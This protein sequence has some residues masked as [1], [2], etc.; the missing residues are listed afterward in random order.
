MDRYH[1]TRSPSPPSKRRRSSPSFQ[2]DDSDFSN[3]RVGKYDE[4]EKERLDE[5]RKIRMAK[6][7]A[8]NEE[9]EKKMTA[10]LDEGSK[11][12][13]H[14]YDIDDFEKYHNVLD[15]GIKTAKNSILEVNEIDI[16]G[17]DEEEQMQ[18][19]LG[20]GSFSSSK[21]KVV[22]DNHDSAAT[23]AAAKN[24]ERKYRQYM[25]RKG[26]FNRPLSKMK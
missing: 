25:N 13:E 17:L 22:K 21:G 1:S 15:T 2:N 18:K 4:T 6:L 11:R 23:G 16:E 10:A 7:R 9:E 19:F 26:G 3:R 14:G 20:F 12:K 5:K 8:E 24:K